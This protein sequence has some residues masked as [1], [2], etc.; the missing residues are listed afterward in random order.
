MAKLLE[1]DAILATALRLEQ[2]R[3]KRS[4]HNRAATRMR[5]ALFPYTLK[6]G[7]QQVDT[8]D[9]YQRKPTLQPLGGS[10]STL[11]EGVPSGT[12]SARDPG[13]SVG[14]AGIHGEQELGETGAT[15]WQ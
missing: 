12:E 5:R 11:S 6:K 7:P 10:C 13:Q 9:E 15:A 8:L 4:E 14:R 2:R 1:D 3:I